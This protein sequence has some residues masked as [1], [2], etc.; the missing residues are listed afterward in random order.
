MCLVMARARC[1]PLWMAALMAAEIS[2][3]LALRMECRR[4]RPRAEWTA[5]ACILAR[6]EAKEALAPR[7]A[8]AA[9]RRARRVMLA[10][11][12]LTSAWRAELRA[13]V[14]ESLFTAERRRLAEW[15]RSLAIC[16]RILPRAMEKESAMRRM[17]RSVAALFLA[18]RVRSSLSCLR[19]CL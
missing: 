9:S 4:A 12:P 7:R 2:A 5:T 11:L 10:S 6:R 13:M 19:C 18:M 1:S 16:L 15:R 8:S 3:L 17:R 14:L